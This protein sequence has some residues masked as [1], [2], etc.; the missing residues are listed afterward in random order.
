MTFPLA[1]GD[2]VLVH[3]SA[4]C[5]DAWWQQG[6]VQP[7]AQFRMHDLSDGFVAPKLYSVPNVPGGISTT[8]AQLRTKDGTSYIELAPGGIINLVA[9][10]G[11]NINGKTITTQDVV[12]GPNAVSVETHLHSGVEPGSGNTGEPVA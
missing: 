11:L 1:A 9:P 7:Q 12:V 2:E 5:L 6:G 4:R 10:G 3:F 8:A